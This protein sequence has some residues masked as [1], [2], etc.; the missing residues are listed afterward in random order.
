MT[1]LSNKPISE[2]IEDNTAEFYLNLGRVNGSEVCDSSMIKYVFAGC[3]YNR[4]MCARFSKSLADT[5]TKSIVIKLDERGIDALWYITP[6]TTFGL[7][8][9]LNKYGFVYKSEWMSMAMD[10]TTFSFDSEY[11]IGLEILEVSDSKHLD[12]WAKIVTC[13]YSLDDDVHRAYGRHLIIQGNDDNFRRHHFLG[14]LDGKPVATIMLFKGKEAAGIYWV[15][16][17]PEARKHGIASSMVRRTLLE[18]KSCGY[19]IAILN[20]NTKGHPLYQ[21]I[22]FIDYYNAS[23]YHRKSH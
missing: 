1:T 22:G 6:A 9:I 20:A 23:I 21:K 13:C 17:L 19:K 8:A 15:G 11:P 5:I 7:S 18:A 10:L 14:L 3:G 16:T 12:A 4:I 2:I